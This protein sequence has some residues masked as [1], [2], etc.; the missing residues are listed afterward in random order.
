FGRGGFEAFKAAGAQ[1]GFEIIAEERYARGD[2]DFTAQ[3][4]RI[5][6]SAAQGL[7]EWSRYAEGA[8]VAKQFVQL[9]MNLPRFGSD[10][11]A[12]PKYIELGG[13]AV[14]GVFYTTH[15]STATT[16]NIAAAKTFIE[17][18]TKA[19]GKEPNAYHAE[20]YD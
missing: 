4:G 17:K 5:K 2:M 13:S 20:A 9:N 18:L 8:L 3:L 7:V 10:G 1:Y 16:T 14:D 6:A 19:Y 12:L 11:V 15:Y